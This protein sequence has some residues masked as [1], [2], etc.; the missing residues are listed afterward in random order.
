MNSS[1]VMKPF[2]IRSF[3]RASVC[4]R[5]DTTSSC[6]VTGTLTKIDAPILPP[7]NQGC[8]PDICPMIFFRH[9]VAR[10]FPVAFRVDQGCGTP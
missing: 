10:L 3:A 6:R 1:W 8:Q 2:S 7:P 5:L 4:A 9:H